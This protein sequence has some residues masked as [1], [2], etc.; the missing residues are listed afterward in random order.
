MHVIPSICTFCGVGCGLGLRVED[1]RVVG[2]EPQPGHPVSA[3]QLCAKGWASGFAIDAGNRLRTPLIK[4]H[5]RFRE[6][7]WDEALG[8]VASEFRAALEVAGPAGV[9]VISCAHA[10]NED[11]YAAQKF[12]R[13]VLGTAT[14]I[15][16]RAS[17]TA[18]R[19]RG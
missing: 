14:S 16:A 5:G 13:A 19:W 6:A 3:G 2:V 7:G 1:G 18:L 12:A 11:N 10:T 8:L 17:A 4:E 9:G 15:I